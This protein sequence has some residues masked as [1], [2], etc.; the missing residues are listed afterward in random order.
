M[1]LGKYKIGFFALFLLFVFFGF[2][3]AVKT[4]ASFIDELK[5]KITDKN[6]KLRDLQKEID[7]YEAQIDRL[8]KEGNSLSNEIKKLKMTEKKLKTDILYTESQIEKT[9][10]GID[11]L[12]VEIEQKQNEILN[13]KT[14]MSEMI[15]RMNEN[16]SQSIVEIAL[17]NNN[18][19]DF[20]SDM[21]RMENFQESMGISLDELNK[22]KEEFES[23]K[24]DKEA[25]RA[26]LEK[27]SSRYVDQKSLVIMNQSKNSKLLNETKNK[28]ANYQKLLADRLAKKETLEE[29][30]KQFEDELRVEIDPA[31]LPAVGSGVLKW[32]L[33]NVTITQYFGNTPFASK[34]P[35]VYNGGG[36]NGVDFRAS[37]GTL[38]KASKSGKV[39]DVGDTDKECAG[40]SYG[41][42][43][44]IEHPNNLTTLYAHLSLIKAVKGEDVIV[45]QT[46]GYSGD[47][48]YSTGP[49]LHFTVYASR[50][51][52][53]GTIT[54]KVCGTKMR[55]PL[56]PRE[57]YLNPLSYL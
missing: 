53:V 8:G 39:V 46:I 29:E 14:V 32:P 54:S 45:G 27:L 42:W 13:Q 26:K 55:L 48:G 49:H 38:V 1:R 9:G 22:L 3:P 57:W 37:I 25:E 47:T 18:F 51:V 10:F 7:E 2:F 4:D 28:E 20:F 19:S 41:K 35:Q 40:V 36:H 5:D 23:Q 16:E 15:R 11:K 44:L 52:E 50:A 34:N 21:E 31:S 6:N 17:A 30:I 56:A 43:V 24:N 12:I 33:D